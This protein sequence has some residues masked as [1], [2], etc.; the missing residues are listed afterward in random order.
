MRTVVTIPA[1]AL[2]APAPPLHPS[3]TF[4]I[5]P[6]VFVVPP[7]TMKSSSRDIIQRVRYRP[8][9]PI[10]LKQGIKAMGRLHRL[11]LWGLVTAIVASGCRLCQRD[12]CDTRPGLFSSR[13]RSTPPAQLT[14]QQPLR[15]GCYDAVTGQPIPCPPTVSPPLPAGS[16]PAPP[17]AAPPSNEEL[18]PPGASEHIQPPGVPSVPAQQ[19]T[20]PLPATPTTTPHQK[21]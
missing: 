4:P 5:A 16:T 9:M 11:L 3:T 2:T 19:S 17:L 14:S 21:R 6:V 12:G 18:P 1:D 15:E 8:A 20:I 13:L 7:A 10:Q